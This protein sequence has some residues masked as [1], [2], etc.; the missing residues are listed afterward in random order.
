[1]E[2]K[3]LGKAEAICWDCSKRLMID[4]FE[5]VTYARTYG[6]GLRLVICKECGQKEDTNTNK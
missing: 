5:G 1:M 6:E 2:Y 3:S 4:V